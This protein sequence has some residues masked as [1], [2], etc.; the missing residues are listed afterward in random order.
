MFAFLS[1]IPEGSS[2]V[3]WDDL[4]WFMFFFTLLCAMAFLRWWRK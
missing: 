2:P 3:V 4:A 1:D